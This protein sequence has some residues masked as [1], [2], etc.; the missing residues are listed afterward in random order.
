[1]NTCPQCRGTGYHTNRSRYGGVG[2]S[3]SPCPTCNGRPK[4]R[5]GMCPHLQLTLSFWG[6]DNTDVEQ[7]AQCSAYDYELE[8]INGAY[9]RP[10]LCTEDWGD[11]R[12]PPD[13]EP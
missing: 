13:W 8:P 12:P 9:M 7:V 4:N 1:M 10:S 5:C 2:Q 11:D 3:Y 6:S